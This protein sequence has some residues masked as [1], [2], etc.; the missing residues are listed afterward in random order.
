MGDLNISA[1]LSEAKDRKWDDR[2]LAQ[3]A[4]DFAEKLR[5]DSIRRLNSAEHSLLSAL[6]RLVADEKNRAFLVQLCKGVL[7]GNSEEKQC[8]ILRKL[9]SD[10]G[11]VPTFF[12]TMA[13][14]RFKTAAF[15]S[16]GMQSTALAEIRRIFRSTFGE[17]TLPTRMDKVDKKV[18]EWG[19]HKLTPALSPLSPTVFGPKA[20]EKYARHLESIQ[21]R[22]TGV[23][24]TIQPWRLCPA[25]SLFAPD[26]GAKQL[27][28]KLQHILHTSLSGGLA[29]PIIIETGTSDLQPVIIAGVKQALD[30]PDFHRANIA[31]EL[32]AYLNNAQAVLRDLVE[33]SKNRVAKGAKP[34]QVLIVKG[35]HLTQERAKRFE[36]GE[37]NAAAPTKAVTDSRFK[38]LVHA[39]ICA[40]PKHITPLVGT[41]NLFDISYA[42]LDWGRSG[43]VGLPH[44]VFRAGLGNH[45]GRSLTREG[46]TVVLTIG[47]EA[48]DAETDGFESHLISLINELSRPDGYLT[49]GYMAELDSM[50]W[51]R[52]RQHFLAALSGREEDPA[53]PFKAADNFLPGN[54]EPAMQEAHTAQFFA[55][56]EQE[57]ERAQAPIPLSIGGQKVATPLTCIHRSLTA[58]GIEDYRYTSADFETVNSILAI[59]ESAAKQKK[60]EQEQHKRVLK[61]AG[62]LHN[63]RTELGALLVRDAGFNYQDSEHELMC[64]I[65]ACY[66]YEL[67]AESDGL[68]D[69][70]TPTPQGI[71]V[72]APGPVHPLADAVAAIAA[73]TLTGNAIIYRPAA[74]NVLLGRK[75]ADLAHE[76]GICEP[77]LQFVPCLDNQIAVKLMTSP[78]IRVIIADGNL[79]NTQ[80]LAEKAPAAA[81]CSQPTGTTT[82]YLSP[83]AD[84][85]QAVRDITQHAFRRSGQSPS[86]PQVLMVHQTIYDNQLFINSLKD[87][88]SNL[89]AAPGGRQE[90]LLGPLA[91]PLSPQERRELSTVHGQE[92][93][94]L[95]PTLPTADTLI[96]TPGIRTGIAVDSP[97]LQ[98]IRKLPIL[99]LMRVDSTEQATTLQ[100]TICG[101]QAAII[102]TQDTAEYTAWQSAL[103]NCASLYHNTCPQARPALQPFGSWSPHMVGNPAV[104]GGKN[105]L[106][107]LCQW[108][109]N[110]R[111]QRR[112]KQRNIAFNPREVLVPKPGADDLMRLTAAA[113]SLSYWWEN[114]FGTTHQLTPHPHIKTELRYLPRAVCMRA[115][116]STT[117]TEISIFLMAALKAGCSIRLSTAT[118]RPWMPRHLEGLGVRVTLENRMEYLK[119]LPELAAEGYALRDTAASAEDLAVAAACGLQINTSPILANGRIELLH[120]LREQYTTSKR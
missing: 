46:A 36:Y 21:A 26:A 35:S 83:T 31:I 85:Q 33:W 49:H 107:P 11:G 3:R 93:W 30:N 45:I 22:Q 73:A 71:V 74:G 56:A 20:A 95:K 109:E 96:I 59:A 90:A 25:L 66:Y 6:S 50:G 60:D 40:D 70:T 23:G 106:I 2:T 86:C 116:N 113:D 10:F 58:P 89:T 110:A 41:H 87:A 103:S 57:Q 102:Y 14:L 98:H 82:A 37:Q 16:R 118:L 91:A 120:Y 9:L 19:K 18:K 119:S 101:G 72:V 42:L 94:L 8:E 77:H 38:K 54:L 67:S 108:K 51:N 115:E 64:A 78:C 12:S 114:E 62:L 48:E 17:L 28:A 55:A 61:L 27:A 105:F 15:A 68:K 99:A 80:N 112:G 75:L 53:E 88:V 47:I 7:K 65:D 13:R 76:A 52:M 69:G 117:D 104:P 111:P 92:T 32:P 44:F 63:H 5:D 43:R 81:I 79:Y 34:L 4:V 39:A 97:L 29:A 100:N 1:I 24:L 84:W